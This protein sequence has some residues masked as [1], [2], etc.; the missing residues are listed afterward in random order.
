MWPRT[1]SRTQHATRGT[2]NIAPRALKRHLLAL[3]VYLDTPAE[4]D[5]THL[6][7]NKQ[8]RSL[9]LDTHFQG[10]E[11]RKSESQANNFSSP[12]ANKSAA[13][14]MAPEIGASGDPA[15]GLREKAVDLLGLLHLRASPDDL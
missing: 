4:I 13:R 8:N 3:N 14:F 15:R 10:P 7:E 5:R 2:R 11:N 9:Y 12:S 6:I 1:T